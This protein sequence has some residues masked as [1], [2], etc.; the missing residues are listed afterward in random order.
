M[1]KNRFTLINQPVILILQYFRWLA[2]AD[3]LWGT[4]KYCIIS[5]MVTLGLV[6]S[7]ETL[8]FEAF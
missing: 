5:D 2:T 1:L 3:S 4:L 8:V 6:R 7:E